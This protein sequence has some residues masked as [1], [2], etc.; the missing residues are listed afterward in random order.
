MKQWTELQSDKFETLW[1][2]ER[3]CTLLRQFTCIIFGIVYHPPG[4]D[5]KLLY[6]HIS[7]CLDKILEQHPLSGIILPGDFNH[8][9]DKYFKQSFGIKQLVKQPTRAKVVLDKVYTN[10]YD[11]YHEPSVTTPLG[12]SDHS[13]VVC[14][15]NGVTSKAKPKVM[16]RWA[17][18]C[19]PSYKTLF[20]DALHKTDWKPI[21]HMKTIQEQYDFF[22]GRIHS[23]VD[24]FLPFKIINVNSNDHP[25]VTD[26][27]KLL[28]QKKQNAWHSGTKLTRKANG[29]RNTT[30]KSKQQK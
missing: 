16:T 18:I 15:P 25:W 4:N 12:L 24:T 23:L 21:Y 3:P 29:C 5:N 10:M 13:C 17:R 30:T 20:A 9:N 8:F 28:V 6:Q 2:T 7:P 22:E 19:D 27:F 11:Y 26:R 1:F 14:Y